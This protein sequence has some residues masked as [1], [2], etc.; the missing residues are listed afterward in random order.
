MKRIFCIIALSL[1]LVTAA[2]AAAPSAIPEVAVALSQTSFSAPGPVDVTITVTAP[3]DMPGPCALYDPDGVRIAGFGTPTLSAGESAAWSGTWQVT[4]AQLDEGK[5]VFGM[6][7]DTLD[8]E[9]AVVRNQQFYGVSVSFTGDA[10]Q[11]AD[12][13]ASSE[14]LP[15]R[16]TITFSR[17]SFI[18]PCPVGVT[19]TV[20]A[21]QD[22]PGPCTLYDPNGV[23]I[24][25]FGTPTL[26]AGESAVWTGAWQ[27]TQAQLD[28]GELV[29]AVVW[30]EP[31]GNGASVMKQQAYRAPL[32][33]FDTDSFFRQRAA[34]PQ[35]RT[36]QLLTA[37][38]RLHM[39]QAQAPAVN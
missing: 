8:E 30:F 34:D 16:A 27:V 1:M 9:G 4:Q 12:V 11:S 20:T 10:P 3:Q 25:E 13:P 21:T 15:L 2:S 35:A 37:V 18:Y 32:P 14:S 38:T 24:A 5:I 26:S 33:R 28:A 17:S 19:I 6:V 39:T 29:F 31:D 23:R 22:M 7:F 36:M